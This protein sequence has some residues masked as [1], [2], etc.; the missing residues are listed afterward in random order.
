MLCSQSLCVDGSCDGELAERPVNVVLAGGW[1]T[2]AIFF[3]IA[4]IDGICAKPGSEFQAY[5]LDAGNQVGP[6]NLNSNSCIALI[7]WPS[8]SYLPSFRAVTGFVMNE[9]V[10]K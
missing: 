3:E 1:E 4:P 10:G 8:L 6:F 9:L 7:Y 5:A 2:P